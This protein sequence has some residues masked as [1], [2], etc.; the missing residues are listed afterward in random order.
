MVAADS[1]AALE[2]AHLPLRVVE[3]GT[4]VYRHGDPVG[5]VYNL[6]S[7]W[8]SLEKDGADGARGLL[9]FVLPGAIF[10]LEPRGA[11]RRETAVSI[12]NAVIC[13][14]SRGRLDLLRRAFPAM[15]ER[16]FWMIERENFGLIESLGRAALGSAAARLSHLVL[17]LAV[18]LLGR[19]PWAGERIGLPLTQ[20]HLAAASGLTT[21]HVSR[22]LRE[23]RDRGLMEFREH[24]LIMHDPEGV[25]AL[26]GAS[27]DLIALWS[28][29]G[30]P[31]SVSV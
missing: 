9:R 8:I 30:E 4:Q 6:I 7:G 10:G 21:V 19:R 28:R 16:L 24:W 27:D 29:D 17:G 11:N 23:L 3:A 2:A 31:V 18:Q 22:V 13:P 1:L 26:C 14:I 12:T 25:E 15:N 5:H 20:V